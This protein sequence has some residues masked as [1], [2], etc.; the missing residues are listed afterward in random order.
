MEKS[1][2]KNKDQPKFQ[3]PEITA[4]ALYIYTYVYP[5]YF[6]IILNNKQKSIYNEQFL[7]A[8]MLLST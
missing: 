6:C 8:G 1:V 2:E 3:H 5:F 7:Y 4:F